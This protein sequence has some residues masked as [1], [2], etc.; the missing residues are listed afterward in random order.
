MFIVQSN[1][2]MIKSTKCIYVAFKSDMKDIG[3]ANV[4]LGIEITRISYGLIL[5]QSYYVD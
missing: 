3:L 5:S 1:Y 4:I 2:K